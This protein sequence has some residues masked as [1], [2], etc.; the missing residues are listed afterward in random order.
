MKDRF[1]RVLFFLLFLFL[2]PAV[3]LSQG[4]DKRRG[5]PQKQDVDDSKI[6]LQITSWS[7]GF[8]SFFDQ[9]S[10]TFSAKALYG[11]IQLHGVG[12]PVLKEGTSTGISADIHP[13][14]IV[15]ET[16]GD[17][18]VQ[19]FNSMDLRLWSVTRVP[20]SA[21]PLKIFQTG[22]LSRVFSG[23]DALIYEQGS[24]FTGDF[25]AR[26]V[27]GGDLGVLGPGNVVAEIYMFQQDIPIA[28]AIF[29]GF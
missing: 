16:D 17:I 24:D 22:M 2:F 18:R 15:T 9:E 28:F 12:F 8:G 27:V 5:R 7:V 6:K 19:S 11:T 29:Y 25:D 13:S 21:V 10:V 1:P 4:Y 20:V 23:V 14:S 26:M 3:V